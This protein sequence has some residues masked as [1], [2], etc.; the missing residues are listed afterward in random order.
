MLNTNRPAVVAG[1]IARLMS[2]IGPQIYLDAQNDQGQG[3]V[4]PPANDDAAAAAAA[5]A[6]AEAAA[7][8]EL[9]DAEAAAAAA[10]ADKD[11][12][13]LLREVMDKKNKL[14]DATIEKERLAGELK[15]F[16]GVD[17][18]LYKQLV[19]DKTTR[20]QQEAEAKG[21]FE[22]V[23]AMMAEQHAAEKSQLEAQIE[24]LRTDKTTL[25]LTVDEL[26]VG[27]NF[28]TS[29]YIANELVLTP[30]KAR[31]L[32][33]AH[34]EQQNGVTVGYDKPK[35][36]A[37]RTLLVGADGKPLSFDDAFR[38]IIDKDP[39]KDFMVKSKAKP[40]SHSKTSQLPPSNDDKGL[41][42]L[43]GAARIAAL[44]ARKRK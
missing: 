28:A 32:Y 37:D 5:A 4:D 30:S 3:T 25:S 40:G 36:A 18:E 21:D 24:A 11:K 29:I 7:A 43:T 17:V 22:R 34:F 33:G 38:K 16:E 23:K 27:Q 1:S 39:E 15:K 9:A 41:E 44:L 19:A 26:T 14:K 35:G 12:K 20:E 42:G 6:D 10:D 8:Q 2:G 31:Q 13:A